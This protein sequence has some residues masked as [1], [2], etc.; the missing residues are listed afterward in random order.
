MSAETVSEAA[1]LAALRLS[2]LNTVVG[3]HAVSDTIGTRLYQ[4]RP[5]EDVA[6]P[7]GILNVSGWVLDPRS[8]NE[9]VTCKLELI[10]VCRPADATQIAALRGCADQAQAAMMY[11]RAAD[12]THAAGG[13]IFMSQGTRDTLPQPPEPVDRQTF[14]IRLTWDLVVWPRFLTQV[15]T[16]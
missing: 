1:L 15:A 7:Y 10:L 5:P 14:T 6:Y 13:I 9:R 3:G 8:R 12:S 16:P 11:Y 2:L 4:Y